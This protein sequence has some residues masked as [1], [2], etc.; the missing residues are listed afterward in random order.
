MQNEKANK[1]PAPLLKRTL[2]VDDI[3]DGEE[4]L[5]EATPAEA[6]AIAAM[7]DL[8]AID[9]LAFSYRLRRQG[10][11]RVGVA[12]A[13]TAKV[14][15]A[16]VITLDPI[17]SALDVPVEIEFWPQALLEE[18]EQKSEGG[19]HA[20]HDWPEPILDGTV[21]LG[22]LVYE[23][24]ATSLDPYPKREDAELSRRASE[25]SAQDE[26]KSPFAILSQLKS[27]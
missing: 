17:Q 26:P 9:R 15:Q 22:T 18:F 5:I 27:R 7:L 8:V 2:K 16:C 3:K 6:K 1:R 23:T 10:S 4:G 13:L 19:D 20:L 25:G 12:G 11:A 14:T 24:L 21:D